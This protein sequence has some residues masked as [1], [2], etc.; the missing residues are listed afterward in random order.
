MTRGPSSTGPAE[1]GA[2]PPAAPT[3]ATKHPSTRQLTGTV[4]RPA[5]LLLGTLQPLQAG[6]A[7]LAWLLARANALLVLRLPAKLHFQAGLVYP[8]H[9]MP[10]RSLSSYACS[11]LGSGRPLLACGYQLH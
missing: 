9:S 5:S 3:P 4:G 1:Q 7:A 8:H 11:P 10:G 2:L 6:L